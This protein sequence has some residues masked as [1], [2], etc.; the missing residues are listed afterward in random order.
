MKRLIKGESMRPFLKALDEC[1]TKEVS[2]ASVGVGDMVVYVPQKGEGE[3]L[4]VHR[5]IGVDKKAN[6]FNVKGD[7]IP[8]E[9]LE[10]VLFDDVKEKVVAV[11]KNGKTI[12]LEKFPSSFTKRIIALLSRYDLTPLRLKARAIDPVLLKIADA[13]TFRSLRKI[14]YKDIS[15]SVSK[16]EEKHDLYAFI[17]GVQS[18]KATLNFKGHDKVLVTSYIRRRDRNAFFAEKFLKK[19]IKVT[20]EEYGDQSTLY[21]TDEELKK[22]VAF[23]EKFFFNKRVVFP[24]QN[25]SRHNEL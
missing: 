18:A 4:I 22:L 23:K 3:S 8:A 9:F 10:K 6:S 12:D 16:S 14:F 11:K 20:E 15:F 24:H 5:V 21:I 7:N 13:P 2:S 1:I 25:I 19:I 17:N